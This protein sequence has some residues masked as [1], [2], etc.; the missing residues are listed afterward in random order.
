M[1]EIKF[2][3]WDKLGERMEQVEDDWEFF[4]IKACSKN[5]FQA[6]QYTGLKDNN[7]KDIYEGDILARFNGDKG[8]V[9][10]YGKNA[11]WSVKSDGYP[12]AIYKWSEN[13]GTK[14]IGNIY[15]NPELLTK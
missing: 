8:E 14:V 11:R 12:K 9:L 13:K 4:S 6:M 10:W 7:G 5:V 1:R 3:V 15:E 2:R